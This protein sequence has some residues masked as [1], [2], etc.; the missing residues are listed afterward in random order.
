MFCDGLGQTPGKEDK[1]DILHWWEDG[2]GH[3][4]KGVETF[5]LHAIDLIL[6]LFTKICGTYRTPS[7]RWLCRGTPGPRCSCGGSWVTGPRLRIPNTGL[8]TEL[9]T[10]PA[11]NS[12]PRLRLGVHSLYQNLTKITKWKSCSVLLSKVTERKTKDQP[13]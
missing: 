3:Y 8:H 12:K 9:Q 2:S 7:A 13:H 5:P 4:G 6:L 11:R 1:H 10:K